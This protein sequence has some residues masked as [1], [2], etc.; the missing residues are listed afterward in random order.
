L[1][2]HLVPDAGGTLLSGDSSLFALDA[3][4]ESC[5]ILSLNGAY[6]LERPGAEAYASHTLS[7]EALHGCLK[8]LEEYDV[9]YGCFRWNQMVSMPSTR[10]VRQEYWGA[11]KDRPGAPVYSYGR[12]ALDQ[13][14]PQGIA[15]VVYMEDESMDRLE[16]I[17]Q[18]L[19]LIPGLDVTSSWPDNLELMPKGVHKGAAVKELA[20]RLG[21]TAANVMAIGD[22]DNDIS[23]IAYAGCGVA[24]GNAS[25]A[26]ERAAKHVTLSNGEDG[27]TEAIERFALQS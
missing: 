1:A 18:R 27:V 17:R 11:H 12:E 5:Y 3:G 2:L 14:I 6:C 9:T 4:L 10:Q 20:E 15:K 13:A 21:I 8:V 26:V 23:M 25:Q 16:E 7:G 19:L 22:Y 24:M